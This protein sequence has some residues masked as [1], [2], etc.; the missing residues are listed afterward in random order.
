MRLQYLPVSGNDWTYAR[1]TAKTVVDWGNKGDYLPRQSACSARIK[2]AQQDFIFTG[3]STSYYA[4]S[5]IPSSTCIIYICVCLSQTTLSVLAQPS[6]TCVP[7][8]S[9]ASSLTV[10]INN[11]GLYFSNTFLPWYF[12][13]CFVASLPAM[14]L[15]ILGPPGCSSTKAGG[16]YRQHS[17]QSKYVRAHLRRSGSRRFPSPPYDPIRGCFGSPRLTCDIV[18]SIFNDDV[19]S[20]VL[21]LVLRDLL[22]GK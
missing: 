3:N 15:R 2:Q 22:L 4:Q 6:S 9:F 16:R 13:N 19:D 8:H 12:Q 14:R 11:L 5:R 1:P 17:G 7:L 20:L 18:D 10:P 21:G